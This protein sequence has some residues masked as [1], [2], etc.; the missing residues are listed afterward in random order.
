MVEDVSLLEEFDPARGSTFYKAE[1]GPAVTAANGTEVFRDFF[2]FSQYPLERTAPLAAPE[3]GTEVQAI[4]MRFGSPV[5]PA[6]VAQA[7]VGGRMEV[8]QA[9]FSYGVARPR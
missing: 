8:R 5:R 6:F 4:D 7:I 9:W 1:A 3:G 2:R